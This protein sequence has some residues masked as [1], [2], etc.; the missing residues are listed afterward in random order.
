MTQPQL[1]DSI[2][3][4]LHFQ[5]NT[6]EQD[7]PALSEKILQRGENG[8]AAEGD[9]DYRRVIGKLNFWKNRQGQIL[10]MQFTN[11]HNFRAILK[12]R[13]SRQ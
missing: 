2:I 9:F 8:Q 1:I 4:E 13:T 5:D 7:T 12:D 10:R 6:K 3:S 11:V